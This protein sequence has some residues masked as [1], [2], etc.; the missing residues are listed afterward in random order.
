MENL[1]ILKINNVKEIIK[2]LNLSSSNC[3]YAYYYMDDE[4]TK[5]PTIRKIEDWEIKDRMLYSFEKSPWGWSWK[6][7]TDH[8]MTVS[9]MAQSI[10]NIIENDY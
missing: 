9:E 7:D 8:F 3:S 5:N 4:L 2:Y 6:S 10:L 1:I